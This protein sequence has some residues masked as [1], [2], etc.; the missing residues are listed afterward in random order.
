MQRSIRELMGIGTTT[1]KTPACCL[2][3]SAT[4]SRQKNTVQRRLRTR[5]LRSAARQS[6]GFSSGG[7]PQ[8]P[9]G[10]GDAPV[11][12]Y[13]AAIPDGS[14]RSGAASMRSS[15]APCPT[16]TRQCSGTAIL[17]ASAPVGVLSFHVL[18]RYVRSG[19][20]GT[21]LLPECCRASS[22]SSTTRLSRHSAN[23]RIRRSAVR[24][25]GEAGQLIARQ[26]RMRKVCHASTEAPAART[27]SGVD[28]VKGAALHA[29]RSTP[30]SWRPN[31]RREVVLAASQ[32][33]LPAKPSIEIP[34]D[35]TATLRARGYGRCRRSFRLLH[36]L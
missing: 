3:K 15:C 30:S 7:N 2:T 21:S 8:I 6:R 36:R 14:T 27:S 12:A 4:R 35:G 1:G 28:T 33:D 5:A 24:R 22:N 17:R 9:E 18:A 32:P 26:K 25:L 19:F 13:I 16:C 29:P 10:Y 34:A 20:R 11:Q 23:R 31:R